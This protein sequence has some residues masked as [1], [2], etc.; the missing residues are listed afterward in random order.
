MSQRGGGGSLEDY[1]KKISLI[2]SCEGVDAPHTH[3]HTHPHTHTHTGRIQVNL[4]LSVLKGRERQDPTYVGSCM[5]GRPSRRNGATRQK[6]RARN[7]VFDFRPCVSQACEE[8]LP[9]I[10]LLLLDLWREGKSLKVCE[11]CVSSPP[12]L[13]A[14]LPLTSFSHRTF[15]GEGEEEEGHSLSA[16][17]RFAPTFFPFRQTTFSPFE[18]K[19]LPP[20]FRVRK[21]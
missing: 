7:S 17:I 20:S 18:K 3:K 12:P 13:S 14:A 19:M 5:E 21:A 15:L 16:F 10:L 4:H 2:Y 1:A 6:N 9:Q 11:R 8:L